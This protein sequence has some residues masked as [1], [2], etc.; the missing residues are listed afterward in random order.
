MATSTAAAVAVTTIWHDKHDNSTANA[1]NVNVQYREFA[2]KYR[3]IERN[4][5]D[6]AK[7]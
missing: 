3:Q 4:I 1:D 5:I 2:L 7:N 6:E